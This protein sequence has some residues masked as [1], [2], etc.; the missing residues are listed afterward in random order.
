MYDGDNHVL[1]IQEDL[2]DG[3]LQQTQYVYG[4]GSG[5]SSFL[6]S[7]DLL[8]LIAY[9]DLS[10]GLAETDPNQH[11]WESFAYD[12]LGEEAVNRN[13]RN[14]TTHGYYYDVLGRPTMDQIWQL[15]AN[16]DGA[17]QLLTTAY[18]PYGN[19][20]LFTSYNAPVGGTVVNQVKRAFNGLG[21]LTREWQS[22]S[23][24]VDPNP[25]VTPSVQYAYSF[26]PAG[27]MNHSRLVSITYPNGRVVTY[28]YNTVGDAT[29]K[30]IDYRVS[31]VSSISD[32]MGTLE[33]YVDANGYS[34][35]LG[36]D[37]LVQRLYPQP[38]VELTYLQQAGD[39]GIGDGGDQYRGLDR[40]GRVVDQRWINPNT[41]NPTD[42]FQY[43]YDRDGNRLY[44]NNLVNA[45]FGE[46]YHQSGA[47]YGCDSLN[48][49]TA[50]SRGVLS[51][52]QQNGPLDTIALPVH[53]QSW[54]LDVM[55]N[56]SQFNSDASSQTRGANRQNEITSVSGQT[57]PTYD[58]N[59]N[60]TKDETGN[61]YVYD[62]WNR[63]VQVTVGGTG[64]GLRYSY[65]ALGRRIQEPIDS[66]HIRDLYFSK[67]W[68][69]LEER[70]NASPTTLVRSQYVWSPVYV[71]ALVLRDRDPNGTGM[72]DE[73]LYVQQDA[74]WNVTAVVAGKNFGT[75]HTGDVVERYVEDPYG[76]VTFL[77]PNTWLKH[78]TGPNG[79]SSV[80]WLYLHQGGR[81]DIVSGLYNFRM[82]DFSPTLGR[83]MQQDPL[84]YNG[85]DDNLYRY[86]GNMPT[87]AIDPSG[88]QIRDPDSREA[89]RQWQKEQ[90]RKRLEKAIK[91]TDA[92]VANLIERMKNLTPQEKERVKREIQLLLDASRFKWPHVTGFF[93]KCHQWVEEYDKRTRALQA[94]LEKEMGKYF[95][96][97]QMFWDTRAPTWLIVVSAAAG[98]HPVE[99]WTEL[100][101]GHAA[102]QITFPDGTIIY[103]DDGNLGDIDH[104]FLPDEVPS[105][106]RP[107]EGFPLPV[108]F[109]K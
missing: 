53:S 21:Q 19:A 49:L 69:V 1:L 14:A 108:K 45:A 85:G 104:V 96:V 44:R 75:T 63:I 79:S 24:A 80:A 98:G 97:T 102:I 86:V 57:T 3:N 78:G 106:Y 74:N 22:H 6:F 30:G 29:A 84:G 93:G 83:W 10:T 42:R 101:P 17:V 18:D 47:G 58:N 88:L 59:G 65:D 94:R 31:R 64:P 68:Q 70:D 105:R 7:N 82:R 61:Q 87:S 37:T 62:A 48:Q 107:T 33:S 92:A 34:S 109:S 39:P 52:S 71:D 103:L 23:G 32:N 16:V 36:L 13:D 40:F 89:F 46:L 76:Q 50:F 56:W 35:Y 90:A 73:R 54:T 4:V 41:T 81:F 51:A 28:N 77:D 27:N 72:F 99:L 26:D 38:N 12:A 25:T 20:Y 9:P 15:G 5:G 11:Q 100:D 2:P 66:S 67:D 91:D 43:G 55:G 60:T 8:G 95:R